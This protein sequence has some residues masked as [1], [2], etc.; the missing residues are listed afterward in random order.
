MGSGACPSHQR[1]ISYH[2]CIPLDVQMM[3]FALN[4][5]VKSATLVK[6]RRYAMLQ[7]F[8]EKRRQKQIE[9]ELK[10]QRDMELADVL[11]KREDPS[12]STEEAVSAF[13]EWWDKWTR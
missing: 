8:K 11:K 1:S 7:F 12:V 5:P 13:N 10:Q 4:F 6:K 2:L 9:Q 3:Y